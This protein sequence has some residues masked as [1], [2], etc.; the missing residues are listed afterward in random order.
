MD[1]RRSFLAI[2]GLSMLAL[3]AGTELSAM[4]SGRGKTMSYTKIIATEDGESHFE[5]VELPTNSEA[6]MEIVASQPCVSWNIS[7]AP[8]G[9]SSGFHTTRVPKIL[10]V[11]EGELEIGVSNGEVRRFG[12]GDVLHPTDT[13][14]KGHTSKLIGNP[15]CRVLAITTE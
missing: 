9:H 1:D 10:L 7:Q 5:D 12:P 14:G 11:L 13:T 2:A 8:S 15:L 3:S 6:P 4:K